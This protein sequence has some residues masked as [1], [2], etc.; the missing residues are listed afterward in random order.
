MRTL[1][2][3]LLVSGAVLFLGLVFSIGLG[4][5]AVSFTELSWRLPL[6]LVFPFCIMTILDVLGWRFAFRRDGIPLRTL[7]SAWIAGE[8]FNAT[9]P[10]AS[11]GGEAVKA[12]LVQSY[13]PL[14]ESVP[15]LIIAKTTVTI[16]QAL[17]LLLGTVAAAWIL[18]TG[19]SFLRGM[20]WLLV[21]E[22]VG[23]GAFVAVQA[24]GAVG[25]GARLVHWLGLGR[26]GRAAALGELDHELT[27]FYRREPRR[28][29]YSVFCY[30]LSWVLGISEAYIVLQ[31]L[32][33]PVSLAT[34][35][36]IE[37]FGTGVS[38]A[39]F[40]IPAKL[41]ALEAGYV[42]VFSAI[43][44]GAPAGLTFSLVRRLREAAW[45]GLGFLALSSLRASTPPLGA[46]E[47]ES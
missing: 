24:L 22:C 14:G 39:A 7:F 32:G 11:L 46:L 19:S 47:P 3:L 36:V 20:R 23:T 5:V 31:A 26:Q 34:A 13:V 30:F 27:S 43:G 42:A 8:S 15:S 45:V 29:A 12:F 18:P 28:L 41:G 44:L 17:F 40:P 9:T 21:L 2:R 38:F 25:V 4:P 6:L 16:G 10:T 35:A 33:I 1:H 37:S